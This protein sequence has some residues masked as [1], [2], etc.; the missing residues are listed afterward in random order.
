[1]AELL[2]S[3]MLWFGQEVDGS[4]GL[5]VAIALLAWYRRRVYRGVLRLVQGIWRVTVGLGS[6]WNRFKAWSLNARTWRFRVSTLLLAM[7]LIAVPCAWYSHRI[8]LV[9]SERSSLDG[10]WRLLDQD[11][12]P[13]SIGGKPILFELGPGTYQVDPRRQPKWI[14]FHVQGTST[15]SK[16][17]YFLDGSRLHVCQGASTLSGTTGD[18][19]T[20]FDGGAVSRYVLERIETGNEKE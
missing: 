13:A 14:D 18:R 20:T 4:V 16:A 3:G 17:I 10:T 7:P 2:A 19:P 5:P 15:V 12:S 9:Q 8:H 6:L 1:M 11:G